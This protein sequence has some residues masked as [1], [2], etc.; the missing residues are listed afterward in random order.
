M[1]YFVVPTCCITCTSG[2]WLERICTCSLST[3]RTDNEIV[4]IA[5]FHVVVLVAGEDNDVPADSPLHDRGARVQFDHVL[6]TG[7]T[8]R[9]DSSVDKNMQQRG[10]KRFVLPQ[11]IRSRRIVNRCEQDGNWVL[12]LFLAKMIIGVLLAS[13]VSISASRKRVQTFYEV[14]PLPLLANFWT[15]KIKPSV[16]NVNLIFKKINIMCFKRF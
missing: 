13:E 10:M 11:P 3:V 9:A 15:I 5:A 8:T 16:Q 4:C 1:Y 6:R 12:Q 7:G 2:V 14:L